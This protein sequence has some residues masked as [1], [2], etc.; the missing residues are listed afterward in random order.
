MWGDKTWHVP[1]KRSEQLRE[2]PLICSRSLSLCSDLPR[3]KAAPGQQAEGE[4]RREKEPVNELAQFSQ[5]DEG[6]SRGQMPPLGI[7]LEC[8]DWV[9]IT[10]DGQE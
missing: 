1:G 10:S 8:L 5:G 7:V 2:I 3:A 4:E 6:K 9:K